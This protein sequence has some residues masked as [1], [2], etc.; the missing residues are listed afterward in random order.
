M[1]GRKFRVTVNGK[2]FIVQVEEITASTQAY[3]PEPR[4]MG[5]D[6]Q[7]IERR[8]SVKPVPKREV[9]PL[10]ETGVFRAPIPG[11]ILSIAVKVGDTVEV[12]DAI[13]ILEAMKMENEIHSSVDGTVRE[14]R[15]S[16]GDRVNK[17][18]ILVVIE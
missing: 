11:V 6:T 1:N 15:V 8:T 18:E 7:T 4:S 5:V 2:T 12:G 9:E 13:L 10:S 14:I 17:G 16:E 3:V